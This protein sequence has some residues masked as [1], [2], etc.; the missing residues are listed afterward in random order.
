MGLKITKA[1]LQKQHH[2]CIQNSSKI[3]YISFYI[4]KHNWKLEL[5]RMYHVLVTSC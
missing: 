3:M 2:K 5:V 1:T 4:L